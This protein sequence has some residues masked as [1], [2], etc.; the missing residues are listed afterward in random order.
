MVILLLN[1][2]KYSFGRLTILL[3]MGTCLV[4][5]PFRTKVI[6]GLYISKNFYQTQ[7]LKTLVTPSI[8][9]YNL[10]WVVYYRAKEV[11]S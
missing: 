4:L 3:D 11:S 10:I 5:L 7:I 6:Y 1:F 2:L 8:S 9:S